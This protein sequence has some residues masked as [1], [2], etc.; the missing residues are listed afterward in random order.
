LAGHS[1]QALIQGIWVE[2][3]SDTWSD[4][5]KCSVYV[6]WEDANLAFFLEPH[7]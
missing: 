4:G 2:T 3:A 7:I 1:K 6:T 5:Q